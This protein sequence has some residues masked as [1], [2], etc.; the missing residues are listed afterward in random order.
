MHKDEIPK[1]NI[2]VKQKLVVYKKDTRRKVTSTVV[3]ECC[4][5]YEMFGS[6]LIKWQ[7]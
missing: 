7:H 2:Q 1:T 3:F 5:V 4:Q 6:T